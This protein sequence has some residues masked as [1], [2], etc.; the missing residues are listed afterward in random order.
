VLPVATVEEDLQQTLDRVVAQMSH[1]REDSEISRFNRAATDTWHALPEEFFTVLECAMDLARSTGGAFD[2][3]IGTL[4]RLW[5]FGPDGRHGEP[6]AITDIISARETCGW[7]RLTLDAETKRARQGGIELDLSGIAKGFAVDQL[8]DYLTGLGVDHYLVEVG[9]ELR[10][11]GCKPDGNPWWVAIDQPGIT[12]GAGQTI[13]ALHDFAVATSGDCYRYFD[14]AGR[15]YSHT[16][17]PRSGHPIDNDIASVTVFHP[18]CMKADAFA[19]AL[20]VLGPADGLEYARR[21]NIAALFTVRTPR[22][23]TEYLTPALSAFLSSGD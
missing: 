7:Q 1:W 11:R 3:A 22:G 13:A 21:Y 8:A 15:R 14:H 2:P 4:T 20:T 17:D 16:L 5:G 12:G 23:P 18:L 10:G 9:G 6:P 19:T